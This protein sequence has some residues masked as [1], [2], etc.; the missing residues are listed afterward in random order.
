MRF[1][2]NDTPLDLDPA[3]LIIA[4]WTG[5][6]AAAIQHHIDE[7]AEL[8]VKPPSTT[9]LFY[10]VSAGLL[11]TGDSIQ[12]VGNASSGE[13]EPMILQSG[14]QRWLGLGSDHTDRAL[15]AH[16]VAMSK[17]VCAKPCAA[18]LWPWEDVADRLEDIRLESWIE[19]DGEW[20]VYQQGTLASIRPL[21]ELI[22]GGSLDAL[23][24]DGAVAMMCGTFG[25]IGGVRPATRFRM[26]MTDPARDR[27]ISHEY[28]MV[29]LPEIA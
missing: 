19:E 22:D 4:G 21:G 14:G 7:L 10:R 28:S 18:R 11:T 16:S 25:A 3:H 2:V 20:V 17:Q 29:Q 15:E 12:V 13:V 26:T 8:G 9:P 23:S 27:S 6:D 5:R 24:R 1:I